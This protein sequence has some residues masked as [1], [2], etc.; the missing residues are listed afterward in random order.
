MQAYA[1]S[2]SDLARE[3]DLM[4]SAQER[5]SKIEENRASAEHKI[6][7]ADME[8]VKVAMELEDSQFNQVRQAF[9]FAQQQ[10]LANDPRLQQQK[11]SGAI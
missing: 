7:Q 1:S 4:A 2:R 8:L 10:K 6:A 3:K 11:A 5:F 9:E